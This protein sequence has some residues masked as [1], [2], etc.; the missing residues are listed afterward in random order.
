MI[1]NIVLWAF[2]AALGLL[3]ACVALRCLGRESVTVGRR[4][5]ALEKP[6]DLS[7]ERFTPAMGAAAVCW[8]LGVL[9]ALYAASAIHC[10]VAR[11]GVSWSELYSAWHHYDAKHY[12]NLAEFGYRDYMENSQHLFLVFFPLYPWL[13]RLLAQLIPNYDLCGHLLSSMCFVGACY[14]LARLTTEEFGRRVSVPALALFAA[15]PFMYFSAAYY[16]ESLFLFL[17]LATF[18]CIRRHRYLFAGIL[19]ALA[20][21]TRMQGILLAAVALVEYGCT[22]HPL[23][24]WRARDW[25]GLRRDCW[26]K[27][28]CIGI[29]AAGVIVYLWLN[30]AV[31]GNP[32]QFTIY[33]REHWYQGF[34]ILPECLRTIWNYLLSTLTVRNGYAIWGPEAILFIVCL[35]AAIYGVRRF[36]PAWMTYFL[37]AVLLNYS[38]SWPLSIGRYMLSA[39][40]L[41]VT[42]AVACRKRPTLGNLIVLFCALIQGVFLFSYLSGNPP[43]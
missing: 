18:Y 2:A 19:G 5:I 37:L 1:L 38:L 35:A 41:P 12:R 14:M 13:V 30:Y 21:L 16:T 24:K 33:Q 7:G 10:A 28:L 15:Y 42:F 25:R 4:R 22:S 34:A 43:Y 26:S 23:Q 29:M 9:L 40:P 8:G 6:L 39:F 17:S 3:C 11:D 20:A 27:L 36:P 31:E 32:F